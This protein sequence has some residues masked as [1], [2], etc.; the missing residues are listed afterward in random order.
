MNADISFRSIFKVIISILGLALLFLISD[1]LVVVFM[2]IVV[3]SA[4]KPIVNYLH[5]MKIPRALAI[6]FVMMSFFGVF[7]VLI[8]TGVTPIL[9]QTGSFINN[10]GNFLE[11]IKLNYN[12]KIPVDSDSFGKLAAQYSGNI[13]SGVGTASSQIVILGKGLLNGLLGALALL[14]LTFYQLLEENKISDFVASLFSNNS[15][16]AKH[17]IKESENKLGAWFRGQLALM[18]FIGSITF[19]ALEIIGLWNPVIAEFALPLAVIAGVLEIVPVLGPTLALLPAVFVGATVSL[20]LMLTVLVTYLII[21][22]I[23]TNIV[24]PRVM[25]RAVGI[26]PVIVIVGIMTGNTLIG[27]L[28]SLL[29]VPIMAVISVL[30]DEW[31]A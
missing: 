15:D 2:S 3:S 14:V 18:V 11:T 17:I 20:P 6:S 5:K 28:G 26:D 10:F 29:S 8:Y 23:E 1:V 7:G 30:Y 9:R 22:Q 31:R 16:K 24:I 27:P 25:N 19:M 12:I 21:Q 13:G 4:L